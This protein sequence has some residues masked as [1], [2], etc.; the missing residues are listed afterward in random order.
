MLEFDKIKSAGASYAITAGGK[1]LFL[2]LAPC[3]NISVISRNLSLLR[4]LMTIFDK[5]E[6]IPL[7]GLCDINDCIKKLDAISSSLDEKELLDLAR[8]LEASQKLRLFLHK[9]KE[10]APD[11]FE[12]F[13]SLISLPEIVKLIRSKID[14]EGEVRENA[15]PVLNKLFSELEAAQRKIQS[16]LARMVK[17]LSQQKL[18]QEEFHTL[19]GDRYVLPVRAASK[20]RVPGIVHDVSGTGETVFIEPL[21][22][23][24]HSNHLATIRIQ[25]KNEIQK[26][27]LE[28]S[29]MIRPNLA[30]VGQNSA[31]IAEFDF[32]HAKARFS[33][34]NFFAIP[35][36]AEEG[37]LKLL[38]AHHPLLYLKDKKTSVP[39]T[40]ELSIEDKVLII[41]GP[42]AGGKTTALK[43]MGILT[44][45]VQSG[46][47]V[48]AFPDSRFPVFHN[49]FA[50]IGDAQDVT[51]G[52]STFSA[53][54]R[55][56]ARILRE[57]D[58]RSL[59][60]LDEL[61]TAT[62]PTE[63]GTLAI[64]IL[65]KLAFS[66]ALIIATS[67]LSPLKAWA[68]EY[69]GARNASFRLDEVTREPTFQI[70]LD[71]PGASEAFL[72]AQREG[73][74]SDVM[75][76]ASQL[77]PK[78]E[79]DLSQLVA[80]LHIKEKELE[81]SRR[82]IKELM[83]EQK[84][85]RYHI[86]ELKD[87]LKEKERRLEEDM[88]SAKETMLKEAGEFIEKRL[89]DLPTRQ[90]AVQAKSEIKKEIQKV[91]KKQNII[92]KIYEEPVD[93]DRFSPGKTVYISALNELGEIK[94]VDRVK[95]NVI[96]LAKGM[97]VTVPMS[98][99][100]IPLP[101]EAS[102]PPMQK[103]TY[104]KR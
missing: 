22:I 27:L 23:V 60:L 34:N 80:S 40:L 102:F 16:E 56:I 73:L 37:C 18:L 86:S 78:G 52:V 55:N 76:R 15:S 92:K 50:D 44:M 46:L 8:F 81:K 51:E 5:G 88:L 36:V 30:E 61:G 25:I 87:Y 28:L 74:P 9:H 47:A 94:A 97:E 69:K 39:I 99:L 59:I 14:D 6:A 98:G 12:T 38:R 67:H 71:V 42:N 48:P 53:H 62:D 104:R 57:S 95:L 13:K 54:I 10:T 82:E 3:Q 100:K 90:A 93:P 49:W 68:H 66:S 1:D 17:S 26:I 89:A 65:E 63:G 21:A 31:L 24:E 20:G 96:V 101:Q 45:M 79:A 84:K 29:D 19:R 72:I 91:E 11:L 64:G 4:Q 77:L 70:M 41:S 2:S 75:R 32:L 83:A 85:L 7:E 35:E 103:I 58:S 33:H 43:T